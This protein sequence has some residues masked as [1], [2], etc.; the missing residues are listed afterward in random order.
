MAG[1]IVPERSIVVEAGSGPCVTTG[2]TI[3]ETPALGAFSSAGLPASR[4]QMRAAL[5][6]SKPAGGLHGLLPSRRQYELDQVRRV[7]AR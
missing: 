5:E 2:V 3:G 6:K 4:L 1:W 7:A